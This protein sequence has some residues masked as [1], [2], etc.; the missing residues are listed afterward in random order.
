VQKDHAP[1]SCLQITA[2]AVKFMSIFHFVATSAISMM[3]KLIYRIL[4]IHVHMGM[5][6]ES[7]ILYLVKMGCH[8]PNLSSLEQAW[9]SYDEHT[10][11]FISSAGRET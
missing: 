8:A 5:S 3:L 10:D 1:V 2:R 6:F 7:C 4:I 9:Y 11:L